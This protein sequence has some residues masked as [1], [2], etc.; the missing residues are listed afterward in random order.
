MSFHLS[1][2]YSC[3]FSYT[4]YLVQNG[5]HVIENGLNS[6]IGYLSMAITF[7][8]MTLT[9]GF[10]FSNPIITNLYL[11]GKNNYGTI[12]DN[13][14]INRS[15]PVQIGALTTWLTINGAYTKIATQSN[16]TLWTWGDN[17]ASIGDGTGVNRSSPTQIGVLTNWQD[18]VSSN[19]NMRGVKTDGTMWVWGNNEKGGTG[20]NQSSLYYNN[21]P[22]QLG[23]DTD[24]ASPA[25]TVSSISNTVV[26]VKTNKALYVWG[27]NVYGALGLNDTVTRSSPVQLGTTTDWAVVNAGISN[28]RAIKTNGTLWT[29]GRNSEGE[30]GD[31]TS[32]PRSSPVQVGVLTNWRL[33]GGSVYA[34]GAIKTDGTL[35]TWGWGFYGQT[36]QNTQS[37]NTSPIQVGTDTNWNSISGGYTMLMATKTDGTLWVWGDGN[38]G[39]LGLGNVNSVSSPT[40]VGTRTNWQPGRY[41]GMYGLGVLG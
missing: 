16:G 33:I 18:G 19:F 38:N 6:T 22:I 15:S 8:G 9:S 36:G 27:D 4:N 5:K 11:V 28:I 10:V 32:A 29:W 2:L 37:N 12:G 35:W 41:N 24:W 26:A 21:S 14:I 3:D 40:Q 13:T 34:I 30:L 17:L 25:A 1:L 20:V 23:T 39:A 7:T 31:G